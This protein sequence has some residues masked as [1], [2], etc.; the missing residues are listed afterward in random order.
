MEDKQKHVKF[1][2]RETPTQKEDNYAWSTIRVAEGIAINVGSAI[3]IAILTAI[4]AFLPSILLLVI[5]HL[6][7][8]L[9]IPTN[10]LVILAF[11]GGAVL[12]VLL[13]AVGLLY[14]FMKK[15]PIIVGLILLSVLLGPFVE[16]KFTEFVSKRQSNPTN[17]DG[18]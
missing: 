15:H 8:F 12:F 10:W 3:L 9:V 11:F 17:K 6:F 18:N 4:V 14:L 2:Q 16:A 5:Q 7:H 13:I 1:D